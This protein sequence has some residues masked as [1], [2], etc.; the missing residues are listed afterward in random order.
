V[1]AMGFLV[2]YLQTSSR[3]L[4]LLSELADARLIFRNNAFEAG[5]L[6]A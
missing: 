3:K 1:R 2:R 6:P 4:T 5:S